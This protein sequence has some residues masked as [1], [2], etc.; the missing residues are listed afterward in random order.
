MAAPTSP[1]LGRVTRSL[2]EV[3]RR[4]SQAEIADGDVR[5]SIPDHEMRDRQ[6][7]QPDN[8]DEPGPGWSSSSGR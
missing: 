7:R 8:D 4:R 6:H 2:Q 3:L 1:Y 5:E